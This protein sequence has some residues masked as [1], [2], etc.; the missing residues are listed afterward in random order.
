ML[1][2]KEARIQWTDEMKE[3]FGRLKQ[4]LTEKTKLCFPKPGLPW[5]IITDASN[6]AAVGVLEQQQEDGN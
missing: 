4:A 5:R 1:T 3:R 2:P 6:Y